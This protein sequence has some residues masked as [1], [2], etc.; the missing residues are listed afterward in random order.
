MVRTPTPRCWAV[1]AKVNRSVLVGM[2]GVGDDTVVLKLAW[3]SVRVAASVGSIFAELRQDDRVVAI[4]A[5]TAFGKLG[6]AGGPA[7]RRFVLGPGC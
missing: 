6:S 7:R 5:D 1:S 2:V 3:Q 4:D